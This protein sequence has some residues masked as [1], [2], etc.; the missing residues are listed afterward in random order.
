MFSRSL[1]IA[2]PRRQ[3][4][5]TRSGSAEG[6]SAP[7]V[8]GSSTK[9]HRRRVAG[10]GAG[11]QSPAMAVSELPVLHVSALRARFPGLSRQAGGR[12]AILAD[13]PGGTQVPRSVIEAM[14]GYLERS[15]ANTGGAFPTSRDTDDLI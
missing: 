10:C 9:R 13:A 14:A 7:G 6:A 15:N 5:P 11:L 8:T 3:P 4:S 12:P 2:P 1:A